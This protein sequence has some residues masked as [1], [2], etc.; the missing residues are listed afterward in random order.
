MF[1]PSG[2]Q[3]KLVRAARCCPRHLVV[4]GAVGSGKTSV[5]LRC[6]MDR[7]MANFAGTQFTLM[8]KRKLLLKQPLMAILMEWS[9][10][11]GLNPDKISFEFDFPSLVGKPNRA[12]MLPYGVGGNQMKE[13]L[14]GGNIGGIFVDEAL[15]ID[16]EIVS[17]AFRRLRRPGFFSMWTLNPDKRSFHPLNK[18][19]VVKIQKGE[20][21]GKV[22]KLR[23][24]DHGGNDP[25]Y[26]NELERTMSA[27]EWQRYGEGDWADAGLAVY[28]SAWR[29][30]PHGNVMEPWPGQEFTTLFAGVD[31]APAGT[32]AAVLVGRTRNG[33]YFVI[34][35]W[36][37]NHLEDGP[38]SDKEKAWAMF[39]KFSKHGPI[40]NWWL[41]HQNGHGVRLALNEFHKQTAYLTDEQPD[42]EILKV[43]V[44]CSRVRRMFELERLFVHPRCEHTIEELGGYEHD[45]EDPEGNPIKENDHF[46]DA[47]RYA[48]TSVPARSV[49]AVAA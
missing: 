41:D 3:M 20:M 33:N 10:E 9:M 18:K 8:A 13:N 19:F 2:E 29:E 15:N 43:K 45:E 49:R 25:E 39:T 16:W 32:N 35:E 44:G 1:I 23:R 27:L 48:V 7:A 30:Y 4:Y 34:D 26:Y 37:H 5:C 40:N 38:M 47:L 21:P 46:M 14:Q 6:F 22:V 28:G 24:H 17:E 11:R 42:R 31:Y 36:R 12:V